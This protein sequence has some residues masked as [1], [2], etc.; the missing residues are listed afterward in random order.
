VYTQ[1]QVYIGTHSIYTMCSTCINEWDPSVLVVLVHI[2]Y[3]QLSFFFFF[4]QQILVIWKTA[5]QLP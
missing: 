3:V 5:S 4:G 1:V 2:H